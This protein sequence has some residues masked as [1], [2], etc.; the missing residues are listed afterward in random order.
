MAVWA[1]R[2]L[3]TLPAQVDHLL[4]RIIMDEC[5][6]TNDNA[7]FLMGGM[8]VGEPRMR[9]HHRHLG[10]MDRIIK[11]LVVGRKHLPHPCRMELII[12]DREVGLIQLLFDPEAGPVDENIPC[13]LIL[14]WVLPFHKQY[15]RVPLIPVDPDRDIGE[16][17]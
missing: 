14:W 1:W 2:H 7:S 3:T 16:N 13:R 17:Q 11:D 15:L 10:V 8:R 4:H 9:T 5:R 6:V 12:N